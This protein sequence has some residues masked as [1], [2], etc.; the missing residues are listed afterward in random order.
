MLLTFIA[1][2]FIFKCQFF[3]S[4]KLSE[5]ICN[6]YFIRLKFFSHILM[7]ILKLRVL[8]NIFRINSVI[9]LPYLLLN[10]YLLQEW[11]MLILS[12]VQML[13]KTPAPLFVELDYYLKIIILYY[14]LLLFFIIKYIH[15]LTSNVL[16]PFIFAIFFA[17]SLRIFLIWFWIC[18]FI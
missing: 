2:P 3:W 7:Y 8:I 13:I 5:A 18:F 15:A 9:H 17:F 16:L 1:E 11:L 6:R 14:L 4:V 12:S 10:R